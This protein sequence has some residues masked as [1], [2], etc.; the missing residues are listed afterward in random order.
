MIEIIVIIA[1]LALLGWKEYQSRLE[2]AKYLNAILGKNAHEIVSLNLSD[3][4]REK[5]TQPEEG[6]VA[7][8]DLSDEEFEKVIKKAN[9]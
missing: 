5:E 8:H 4:P 2:R 3:K 7:E 6:P 1:L 9:G